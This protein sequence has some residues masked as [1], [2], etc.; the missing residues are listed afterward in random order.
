[1]CQEELYHTATVRAM[2][3]QL[4]ILLQD[5]PK[6]RMNLVELADETMDKLKERPMSEAM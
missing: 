3:S 6:R 2:F 4:P 5:L 1:M